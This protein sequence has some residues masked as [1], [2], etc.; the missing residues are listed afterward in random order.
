MYSKTILYVMGGLLL[1]TAMA[2]AAI[3]GL[4]NTGL[5]AGCTAL[6]TPGNG[7]STDANWMIANPSPTAPSTSPLQVPCDQS[8]LLL[9]F[10]PAWVNF[11]DPSWETDPTS[12]SATA[13]Q[14]ITPQVT[15]SVGGQYIYL[16]TFPVPTGMG[17]VT[18]DGDVLSDNEVLAIYLN[19]GSSE[20]I[21]VAGYPYDGAAVNS[22][23]NFIAP[24]TKFKIVKMPVTAGGTAV[25][26]FLVRNRGVGGIDGNPTSTGLRVSFNASSAFSQ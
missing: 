9:S 22:A 19:G 11:P 18:I 26:Y 6:V 20:C 10:V 13:S 21:A 3:P 23:S 1:Y 25:L 7:T 15:D 24:A 14:W 12:F 5:T 8:C 2:S 16:T 4:C 17:H